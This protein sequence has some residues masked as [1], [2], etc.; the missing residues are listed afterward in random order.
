MSVRILRLHQV[1]IIPFVFLISI[2]I[3]ITGYFTWHYSEEFAKDFGKQINKK[4][5]KNIEADLTHFLNHAHV[6]NNDLKRAILHQ[7]IDI[8]DEAFTFNYMKDI[9]LISGNRGI[10]STLQIGYPNGD[11]LGVS[12]WEN[13]IVKKVSNETTNRSFHTIQTVDNTLVV[14]LPNYD[15]R[16]RPWF[17]QSKDT[18][19]AVWSP[20]YQM[21]STNQLA[22]TLSEPLYNQTEFLGIVGSDIVLDELDQ[23]LID[24]VPTNNSYLF[25]LDEKDNLIAQS[26]RNREKV[27]SKLTHV[28]DIHNPLLKEVMGFLR[29]Q[30]QSRNEAIFETVTLNV[31]NKKQRYL[32]SYAPYKLDGQLNWHM[33][34]VMP[35]SDFLGHANQIKMRTLWAWM[36]SFII[37]LIIGVLITLLINRTIQKL[38][39]RV[40]HTEKT[41]FMFED[42]S[43]R[44][45][46][47]NDLSSAFSF[48]SKQFYEML[49][50]VK[51]SNQV[52][53]ETVAQR[54]QALKEVNDELFALAH[55]DNLTQLSNRRGLNSTLQKHLNQLKT[56][57]ISS[58]TCMI[59]DIDHFRQY[60]NAYGHVSG[61]ECLQKVANLVSSIVAEFGDVA[62]MEGEKFMLTLPNVSLVLAESIAKNIVKSTESLAIP[63]SASKVA[64]YLTVSVGMYHINASSLVNAAIIQIA[65]IIDLTDKILYQA[66]M[67]GRNVYAMQLH[68]INHESD[69]DTD[70]DINTDKSDDSEKDNNET[71]KAANDQPDNDKSE[72][73]NGHRSDSIDDNDVNHTDTS[74]NQPER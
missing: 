7:L 25:L 38:H 31:D 45:K 23:H 73:E 48:L 63:H 47:I 52:L 64:K 8:Q 62:R 34:V 50:D 32:V 56:G 58:L 41:G 14:D 74:E 69:S 67:A 43:Y 70:I 13:G 53:E 4:A 33:G 39:E 30:N 51:N 42:A 28:D 15:A 26:V 18:H 68:P 2:A 55:T 72:S 29:K 71:D 12:D 61:D 6:T 9:L 3:L 44:I 11:Y 37:T 60:N 27:Q 10:V 24:I 20:I 46:E 16:E 1:L 65:D 21:Y 22:T 40:K 5:V 36:A 19:S 17:S 54:T 66:K 57:G 59:V 49:L 35:Q